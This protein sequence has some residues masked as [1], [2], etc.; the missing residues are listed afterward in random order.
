MIR[1]FVYGLTMM[2]VMFGMLGFAAPAYAQ[3]DNPDGPVRAVKG[4]IVAINRQAHTMIVSRSNAT[5]VKIIVAKTTQ[6]K[7]NGKVGNFTKL[8]VGDKTSLQYNPKTKRAIRVDSTPGV[9]DI[10]GTIAAVN[11]TTGTIT[12]SPNEGGNNVLLKVNSSTA[13]QRNGASASLADLFVGDLV[14]AQYN[15]A[16]MLVS[17]LKAETNSAEIQGTI[18]DVDLVASTVTITPT[19]ESFKKCHDNVLLSV[20]ASTVI[21]RNGASATLADLV[22]GDPVDAT[23]NPVTLLAIEIKAGTSDSE[24]IQGIIDSIDT[25]ASTVTI[26]PAYDGFKS[27]FKKCHDNI[28]LNVDSSTVITRNDVSVTLSDLAAGDSV[29]ATYNPI[30]MLASEIKAKANNSKITGIIKAID[31]TA[32][33]VTIAPGGDSL[34]ECHDYLVLNVETSTVIIRNDGVVTLA[35]LQVGD[36]IEAWY[37]SVSLDASLIVAGQN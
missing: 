27:G 32:N 31:T 5:K 15:S 13:I 18:A 36:P 12:I 22:I 3:T 23:Y 25:E 16:T 37:D 17:D 29:D 6:I 8:R 30:S 4:R 35:D 28:V 2:F 9:Y 24:E 19:G 10:H 14:E 20:D 1:K 33:T 21:E 11:T 26:R 7:R 34:K